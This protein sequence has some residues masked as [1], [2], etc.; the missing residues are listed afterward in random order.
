MQSSEINSMV[1][2]GPIDIYHVYKCP[3]SCY[4]APLYIRYLMTAY[5]QTGSDKCSPE[6]E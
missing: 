2:S 6:R 4:I 3:L 1:Q 5:Y